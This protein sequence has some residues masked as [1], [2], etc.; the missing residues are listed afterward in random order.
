MPRYAVLLLLAACTCCAAAAS[1]PYT[2]HPIGSTEAPYGY[3]EHLPDGYATTAKAKYPLV[4]FLHGLG[5]LGDSNKDLPRVAGAGP[6]KLIANHDKLSAI[7]AQQ[8]AIVI[9]PQGLRED[10]WWKNEKMLATL[11]FI[12]RTHPIDLDR[13]YITGLSMGGGGTW[14]MATSIPDQL[15]AIIPICGAA[16]PGDVTKLHGLPIW[17][18][19]ALNDGTVKFPDTTKKWFDRILADLKLGPDGGVMTGYMHTDKPWTGKQG[20]QWQEGT[21]PANIPAKQ[22]QLV[23]TVY[24]DGSHDSWSRTYDN[25]ALWAWLFAQ[26]RAKR[27]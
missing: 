16:G 4:F 3:L 17:A 21:M 13:V 14:G 11:A 2:I 20:W 15:A 23:L 5:E 1:E 6:L 19:H 8:Q 24:P 10:K 9:A 12:I 18:N 27:H 7:F 25:P 22:L 26:T